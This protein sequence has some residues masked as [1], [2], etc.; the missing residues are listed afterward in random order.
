V[1]SMG[2]GVWASVSP[3]AAPTGTTVG[4]EG[5]DCQPSGVCVAAGVLTMSDDSVQGVVDAGT[6]SSLTISV[7]APF[8]NS[9]QGS[10]DIGGLRGISCPRDG[11]C[12]AAGQEALLDGHISVY[13]LPVI[14]TVA[15]N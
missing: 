6:T 3:P 2:A 12:V 10:P 5:V 11:S 14:S 9:V 8:P 1:D 15:T 7:E 4:L 13:D